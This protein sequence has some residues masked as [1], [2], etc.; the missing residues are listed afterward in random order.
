MGAMAYA[1]WA[2]KR[3]PTEA[4]WESAARGGL[5]GKKYPWGN[6]LDSS[7]ANYRSGGTTA[8]GRYPPNKYGLYDMVGNVWEWCL[9][10]YD[11]DFYKSSPRRNPIAGVDGIAQAASRFT[12][13]KSSRVLRGGAW[14]NSRSALRVADR[15]SLNPVRADHSSGFRC[16][17][18][19]SP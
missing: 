5:L 19:V 18:T 17:M 16:A 10:A 8:V 12:T 4:E 2:G 13:V 7:K 9:D 1:E 6:L 3:L 15:R 14:S 11:G